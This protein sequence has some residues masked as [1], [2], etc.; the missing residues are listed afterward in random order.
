MAFWKNPILHNRSINNKRVHTERVSGHD[1]SDLK[2]FASLDFTFTHRHS[3]LFMGLLQQLPQGINRPQL[4]M[5]ELAAAKYRLRNA[6]ALIGWKSR[7]KL[8]IAVVLAFVSGKIMEYTYVRRLSSRSS[9]QKL[10][11]ETTYS[12]RHQKKD[13][14]N[15]TLVAAINKATSKKNSPKNQVATTLM[16]TN[17]K[18]PKSAKYDN[19]FT[20]VADP[21]SGAE[22]VMNVLEQHDVVC[23]SGD[24]PKSALLPNTMSWI[25]DD[26]IQ[27]GC[28]LAYVR[29]SIQDIT[30]TK[31]FAARC[32]PKYDSANDRYKNH[33]HRFCSLIAALNKTYT[34]EAIANQ[35]V[36]AYAENNKNEFTG[37][38]CSDMAMLRGIKVSTEW[39]GKIH[40][41]NS[42]IRGSK[43]IRLTR[44]NYFER[45]MSFI[46][47][48]LS[49][50]WSIQ[51]SNDKHNQLSIFR[52]LNYEVN[53]DEM[54]FQFQIMAE[55]EVEMTQW[56]EENSHQSLSV[57][58]S[59][60]LEHPE[61]VFEQIFLFLGV[62][63]GGNI[64]INEFLRRLKASNVIDGSLQEINGATL[65]EHIANRDAVEEASM[66]H[67]YGNFINVRDAI[68]P[69][70]HIVLANGADFRVYNSRKG[71]ET[72]IISPDPVVDT[73]IEPS[74]RFS[75]S[76]PDLRQLPPETI[77]MV[78][79]GQTTAINPHIRSSHAFFTALA[80]IRKVFNE[81]IPSDAILASVSSNCCTT[82]M[83]HILP[84][85]LFSSD[86]RRIGRTCHANECNVAPSNDEA[87]AA[88][89]DFM[90][91]QSTKNGWSQSDDIHLDGT[92]IA[93]TAKNVLKL[94]EELDV[95]PWED[96]RAVLSDFMYRFPNRVVLDYEQNV[97][98]GRF[99]GEISKLD[100]VCDSGNSA[101]TIN[102]PRY[103][104]T[105][106]ALLVYSSRNQQ[107][108]TTKDPIQK[109]PVWDKGGIPI[110]PVLDHIDRALVD[111]I[112]MT[113]IDRHFDKEIF[114][115][116]DQ[117]GVWAS[118]VYRDIYRVKPTERFLIK[119]H[120][121][122]LSSESKESRWKAL[123]RV[124]QST[125][126][127]Y[128]GWY[129]D[130][131]DC[132][133]NNVDDGA[134]IPLF[135]TCAMTTCNNS[136][137]MPSYMNIIDSQIDTNA[138]YHMFKEFDE[139][140]KWENKIRQVVW[141]GALSENDPTRV[142][143]SQRWRLCKLVAALPRGKEKDMFDIGLTN[144]PDFLTA[145][146]EIDSSIV[147]G[148]VKGISP[149]N[150]FQ[151]YIA[152]L[153]LDGNSWSSRFGTML[154][155][156]SVAIKVEP[157]Y[158]D[159]WIH[160]LIPWKHYV[161]IKNDLS[162]L[163]ENIDYVLDPRN[164][165]VMQEII[166]NANQWCS[167]RFTQSGLISDM[168]D[169]WEDYVNLLDRADPDW[170]SVWD[171]KKKEIFSSSSSVS[172]IQM[173]QLTDKLLE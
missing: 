47:A 46:I 39:I 137:P 40:I 77:V 124:V 18:A 120:N 154:C 5:T 11:D 92:F 95:L 96:D 142:F 126:L 6:D 50:Q 97:F 44:Q 22:Y 172:K 76:I 79:N 157:A 57:D 42:L 55:E 149:M 85:T 65:L 134:S 30:S 170:S 111:D 163:L 165:D 73:K 123:R 53:I 108:C 169:I 33:L 12:L 24:F 19:L 127:P 116:I 151:K 130:W 4:T 78:S 91:K 98:G 135:T 52:D 146:I 118:D 74:A 119:A 160:D 158:A 29:E 104:R 58:R 117:S 145:Q 34:D 21:R 155:Y 15:G 173:I 41:E 82:A 20:I 36:S 17:G 13:E 64:D 122:L 27:K 113:G 148:L 93:G 10:A 128:F 37:C 56:I 152:V 114:Y 139:K 125:G 31:N 161:P 107:V 100:L 51:N 32:K 14:N 171:A 167:E 94:I 48:N 90:E 3:L 84:G 141:R 86:G 28:T 68:R 136:F 166:L 80:N 69:I 138:W 23:A 1:T 61:Q 101:Y 156:N 59:Q 106:T 110:L 16:I 45:Y 162:D 144:I 81:F 99:D 105:S 9:I 150:D 67:G 66:A 89:S 140:Y 70:R 26:N 103:T 72:T 115:I 112:S 88:W 71:Y 8:V 131:K 2:Y 62:K 63:D 54:L 143:D 121:M 129:G 75:Q 164:D 38:G 25:P 7:T 35:F 49:G 83:H 159:Y 168:L 153:D 43:M 147:G 102:S 132:N 133:V 109:F 60:I 87:R